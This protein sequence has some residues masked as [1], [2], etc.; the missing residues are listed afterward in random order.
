MPQSLSNVLLH[1][2]FSTKD[3]TPLLKSPEIRNE[4]HGY[5]IGTL[6]NLRC[7]S[8][9]IGSVE[10]HVHILCQLSRTMAIAKL[11]EELKTGSSAWLKKQDKSLSRFYW[12]NGYG[13]SP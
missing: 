4:L 9:K 6:K 11:I 8:L 7:P 13:V 1:V 12:Q 5:M 2:I 3:R 10:D